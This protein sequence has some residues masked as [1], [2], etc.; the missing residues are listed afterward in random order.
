MMK[1]DLKK[2]TN[3]KVIG[4]IIAGFAALAAFNTEIQSQKKEKLI[5]DLVDRVSKLEGKES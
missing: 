2:L 1:F 3:G 5:D 4:L